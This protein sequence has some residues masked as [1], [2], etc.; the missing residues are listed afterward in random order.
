M[1]NRVRAFLAS[2]IF[3]ILMAVI[4]AVIICVDQLLGTPVYYGLSVYFGFLCFI[5]FA[6]SDDLITM[7]GPG[8]LLLSFVIQYKNSF[9][10][11]MGYL[12]GIPILVVCVLVHVWLGRSSFKGV[13]L[14]SLPLTKPICF[15]SVAMLLGGVGITT[16]AEYFSTL[17]IVYMIMLGP[18]ILLVYWYFSS[19][20]KASSS[21]SFDRLAFVMVV[22]S[23]FII[24]AIFEY[25]GEHWA[26]FISSPNILPFQ[27]R[28]NACTLLM[29]AMPFGFYLA[30]NRSVWFFA[31]PVLSCVA[32]VLSGS[33]GGLVFGAIEF[34]ILV[35]YYSVVDKPHKWVYL[36]VL[37]LGI[38]ACV[39]VVLKFSDMLSYTIDRFT[40]S[41]ENFRRIGLWKRSVTD[42]LSNPLFGRGI[43]YMGNRDFHPSQVGQLCW[44]HSS[45]PQVIGSMGI[46]GILAYGYQLFARVKVLRG[47]G[48][49]GSCVLL[50]LVGLELM[51]LVNPGIFA[52]AY[53]IIITILFAAAENEVSS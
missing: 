42:F 14:K 40:S 43:G 19:R 10:A 3:L 46:A 18:F 25:Y 26:K 48:S 17:S 9:D 38:V 7:L 29:I 45:I 32:I 44:Y 36:S 2:D 5:V 23:S 37:G 8:L 6:L 47:C 52:P 39:V 11:Y 24:F 51:S 53:L 33:R 27:W 13:S 50:S 12:W 28:N 49:A 21:F 15:A 30:Q 31:V 1:L 35:I 34:L 20:F 41:K 4:A 22:V 16:T